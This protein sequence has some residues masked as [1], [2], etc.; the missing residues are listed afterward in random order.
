MYVCAR[1][2]DPKS[3]DSSRRMTPSRMYRSFISKVDTRNAFF[4]RNC[5]VSDL[6]VTG[7]L[8][9]GE[10]AANSVTF[11]TTSADA[12]TLTYAFVWSS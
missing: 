3:D 8:G 9:S 2:L 6:G 11:G 5:C 1:C 7:V 4:E 12:F 10:Y